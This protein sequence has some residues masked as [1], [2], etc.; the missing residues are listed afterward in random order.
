MKEQELNTLMSVVSDPIE[1][2]YKIESKELLEFL[3]FQKN[4]ITNML[5]YQLRI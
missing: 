5:C 1:N 4:S 3:I 2:V